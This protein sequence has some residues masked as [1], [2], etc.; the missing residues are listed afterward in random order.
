F[1]IDAPFALAVGGLR[2][3]CRVHLELEPLVGT[4]L[5]ACPQRD[6]FVVARAHLTSGVRCGPPPDLAAPGRAPVLV[7]VGLEKVVGSVLL[8]AARDNCCE[9]AVAGEVGEVGGLRRSLQ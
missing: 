6:A 1:I 2:G 7:T 9:A 8:L 3:L 5:A 4:A